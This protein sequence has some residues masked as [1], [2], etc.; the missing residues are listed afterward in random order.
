MARQDHRS[1][2]HEA[3]RSWAEAG[4]FVFP[5]TPQA[6]TPATT[7]GLHDATIDLDQI[8]RW[9]TSNPQFNIGIAPARSAMFVLDQDGPLGADTLAALEAENGALPPTLT[10]QTP[11]GPLH[12]HKWFLGSCPSTVSKLGAKLDTRGE[13]GY[14]LVPPSSVNGSKYA[15]VS[16][17]NDIAIGPDWISQR[18]AELREHHTALEDIEFDQ[19]ANIARAVDLLDRYVADGNVAVENDGGDTKVY[20][21]ACEVLNLGL[22]PQKCFDVMWERWAPHCVPFNPS[23]FEGFLQTKIV[24][25]L[26]YS[27]NDVGAWA[28]APA[29]E[30]FASILPAAAAAQA[31][32]VK[33]SKFYPRDENEQNARPEPTWLLDAILPAHSTIMMFGPSGSFKSFLAVDMG[34]TLASGIAGYGIATRTPVPV[35]YIAAEGAIGVERYRRPSW[36]EA[37]GI[38]APLPFFTID[39]MPL[40]GR[41][42]EV[43]ELIEAIKG[44]GIKPALVVVDT[45]HR[46]MAGKN[47]NDAKDTGELIEGFEL[48]KRELDCS[49]M[50]IH[51]TG[52]DAERGARGSSALFADFDTNIEVRAREE[53]KAVEL[54]VRKHKDAEIP[55]VPWTFEGHTVGKS[56]VFF[57]TDS[58][59]HRRLTKGDDAFGPV[60]IGAILRELHAVGEVAAVTTHVLASHMVP[61]I[62]NETA[63]ERQ[64]AVSRAARQLSALAKSRLEGYTLGAGRALKWCLPPTDDL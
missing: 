53:T 46:A 45:I 12:L 25:A 9:W 2:L 56:L 54:H 27:Q 7:N 8:D 60:K 40:I 35:V 15:Y 42:H 20:Q 36:R 19:P 31:E 48:I 17:I 28:T 38:E 55:R 23:W 24:N 43:I 11:R 47:E 13:G 14:V 44:R 62:V 5:C 3:A 41:P 10:I 37:R 58:D 34:L 16:D 1:A 39:A 21:V 57:P 59:T 52:K 18:I 30:T 22:S 63:E 4:F 64:H 50:G 29:A 32:A 61:Q 51:H 49:V 6:K 26:E 33:R